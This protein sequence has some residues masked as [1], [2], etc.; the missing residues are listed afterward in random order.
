MNGSGSHHTWGVLGYW[1]SARIRFFN[2]IGWSPVVH[3]P[4]SWEGWYW[5]AAHHWGQSAR[6]G[7]GETYGTVEDLLQHAEMV[8]F[9]SSDPE[10]TSGVYGAHDGTIRRQ[11][12][13]ELGIPCVHIDPYHN[14][15][16]QLA[17]RQVDRSAPGH[18]Q[19]PGAGHRPRL[20][21]RGPLRRG[22][23]RRA[24][25]SAS[26]SGSA[27]V[28]GEEDGVAK[29]PEWQEAETGV[30]ARDVRA[31][32]RAW[33][34]K[35]TYLAAGGLIGFG[36][37]CRT[38]TGTDWA[39]GVVCLMAMQGLGKPGVNMGCLQQGTPLDTHFF[40]PG[41]AEGGYS[42]DLTGTALSIN[43][44]QRMPQLPTVNTVNQVVPRLKIPEAVLDGHVRGVPHRRQVHRG[45]VPALR[46]PGAGPQRDQDV[47]Q[48]R[49]LAL[50]HDDRHQPVR[51]HVPVG[52]AGVRG[53]PGDL[54]GGGD[55]VRRRHPAGLHQLRALG[56]QRVRQL[57]RLHPARLHAVQPPR[58][59]DAAQVHR[60]AGRV[61]SR[62]TRSSS[63]SPSGSGSA[64]CTPRASPSSTGA[65][66]CSTRPTCRRGISWKDFLKKGYYVVPPSPEDRRDPVSYRWFA[67][68]RAKDTPGAHA[69]AG[70][71]H[72]GVRHGAADPVG[73]AG[74][75]GVEPQALRPRRP[76]ARRRSCA[77]CRPGRGRTPRSCT[78]STRCSSSRRTRGTASTR[79]ATAR[80][81]S[82]NDIRDH[83]VLV[84]GRYYWVVRVNPR[85]AAARGLAA[86]RARARLQRPRRRDLRGPADG[87]RPGRYSALLRVVRPLRAGGRAG[88]LRR[89]GRVH[90]RAHAEPDDD[91]QGARPRGQLVSR[92]RSRRGGRATPDERGDM[93]RRQSDEEGPDGGMQVITRAAAILGALAEPDGGRSLA[94]LAAQTGLPKTTVHRICTALEQV[95][96]VQHRRRAGGR[97]ELG[98]SLLRLAC[99]GRR[100]L[101][102][103][104]QPSLER[105]SV[106]L[107]ETV[108]LGRARR[109]PGPVR[110][111]APG[112]AA[113]A[114]GDRPR[115]ARTSP[116]TAWPAARCC[117]RSC[118]A[119]RWCAG[120]RAGSSPRWT[121]AQRTRESLLR[122]LDEV[123]AQRARLRAR[124]DAPRHLR[125]RRG[126]HRRGRTR[127][128][129]RGADAHGALRGERGAGGRAAA[130]AQGHRPRPASAAPEEVRRHEPTLAGAERCSAPAAGRSARTRPRRRDPSRRRRPT[131]AVPLVA[132]ALAASA[133]LPPSSQY[134]LTN[135]RPAGR[136]VTASRNSHS[137]MRKSA[138]GGYHPPTC[139]GSG[140]DQ[141]NH[142]DTAEWTRESGGRNG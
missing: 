138:L 90:E 1:L 121:G 23:R 39:R 22:V 125:R 89:Q 77:T 70:R 29:T 48:V 17:R 42:G 43:M 93:P 49:R 85:D 142:K 137:T 7:G 44:Y 11:W 9:W 19:R 37:A 94:Q 33:G 18:R 132:S 62:T 134:R 78:R 80:T 55:E 13:K 95:G 126:G 133:G 14:H 129:R 122:E 115:R 127:R 54:D 65:S 60:A 59:R 112:A 35:K 81:R 123:R 86:A 139:P 87:T 46:V 3:N 26:R 105:L 110:R 50:R 6:N 53:Q 52:Q 92:R 82:T 97:R 8:V 124:G 106:D 74:V 119:R 111:A 107:N 24:H 108:D 102:A 91:P 128:V 84:D 114:H 64:R 36:G 28:L 2:M 61:A 30:P 31:L 20:D 99:S 98:P 47:L 101:A 27:Y 116:P 41:Y 16:A 136:I 10:A 69:A 58:R 131:A 4:D 118:R 21:D 67:E 135:R 40:F 141:R 57:R 25:A 103:L 130:G 88:A 79:R 66:G 15:T 100:D 38:A 5:G 32:A 71:L 76:G 96:Y 75:R 83:R 109:R 56:H 73:Q 68:G 104:L 117:W 140:G 72:G 12:L 113:G 34:K 63:S 45:P 51:A 120:C